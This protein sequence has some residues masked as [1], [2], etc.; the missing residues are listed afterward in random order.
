MV[1]NILD[2]CQKLISLKLTVRATVIALKLQISFC[3]THDKATVNA[4]TCASEIKYS[5]SRF[6]QHKQLNLN[7]FNCFMLVGLK[8][9]NSCFGFSCLL[10]SLF[11]VIVAVFLWFADAKTDSIVVCCNG[12]KRL[13]SVVAFGTE[14]GTVR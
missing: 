11:T 2:K 10:D 9:S 7:K 6:N 13:L 3:R 1:N 14:K 8:Y 4:L 5:N 12:H